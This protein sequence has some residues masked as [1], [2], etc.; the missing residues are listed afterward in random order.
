MIIYNIT[1]L[2]SWPIHEEWKKWLKEEFLP[3]IFATG[4][5]S[6]YQLVKLMEV[7]EEDGVTYA[8][9]LY[10][11][12]NSDFKSF[13]DKHLRD[14]QIK[15]RDAWGDNVCSFSSLMEVIN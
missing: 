8:I 14:F 3:E 7:N 2:V 11:K 5:F 12:S 10:S 1:T 9:Q 4:L 6:H 13:R 15:E